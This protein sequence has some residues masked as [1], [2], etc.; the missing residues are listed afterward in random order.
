LLHT[1]Q[2]AKTKFKKK[3][4]EADLEKEVINIKD[5]LKKK[6]REISNL[7]RYL[8]IKGEA[9][10][11]LETHFPSDSIPEITSRVLFTDTIIGICDQSFSDD[12][13]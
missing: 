8:E 1:K 9:K 11:F 13:L 2:L 5:T 7:Y 4:L 3:Y 12:C 10:E 6:Y